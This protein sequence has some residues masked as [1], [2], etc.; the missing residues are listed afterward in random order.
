MPRYNDVACLYKVML[1]VEKRGSKDTVSWDW[2]KKFKLNERR[3][4]TEVANETFET[5][6]YP[7]W[8][9]YL[10]TLALIPVLVT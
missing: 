5:N 6:G 4:T 9:S 10:S 2:E 3:Y 8:F 1:T 7:P